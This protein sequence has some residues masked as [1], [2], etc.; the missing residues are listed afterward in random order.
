MIIMALLRWWE[1]LIVTLLAETLL[2]TL[3]LVWVSPEGRFKA[4]FKSLLMAPIRYALIVQEAFTIARFAFDLW[5]S[6]NRKWR[7]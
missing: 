6:G 5:V 1:P 4:F 2:S 7:K 3:I